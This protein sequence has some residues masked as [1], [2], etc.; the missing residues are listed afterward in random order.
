MGGNIVGNHKV[1]I[2]GGRWCLYIKKSNGPGINF[3]VFG[4][5]FFSPVQYVGTC[6]VDVSTLNPHSSGTN[7]LL[8]YVCLRIVLYITV[9]TT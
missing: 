5:Y 6:S 3:A 2:V 9:A 7:M 4:D 8:Q 1:F